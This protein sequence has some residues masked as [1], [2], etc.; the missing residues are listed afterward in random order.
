MVATR[1]PN[2]F[3]TKETH[4]ASQPKKKKKSLEE[5]RKEIMANKTMRSTL[6]NG[7]GRKGSSKGYKAGHN[8][9]TLTQNA[10][11]I[12]QE[13]EDQNYMYSY[14]GNTQDFTRGELEFYQEHYGAYFE[15]MNKHAEE[16]RHK[17]R[18]K[19][20]QDRYESKM[21][22]PT[23]EILQIGKMNNHASPEELKKAVERYIDILSKTY[24]SNLHI[25]NYAIHNDEKVPHCHLR[26]VIDCKDE[27]TG[28]R[29][30]CVEK[31][32][33]ELGIPLPDPTHTQ[34]MKLDKKTG[35]QVEDKKK[36][37]RNVTFTE[38]IRG[39]WNAAIEGETDIS[40]NY[41][42]DISQE[43]GLTMSQYI[44]NQ[45]E[46]EMDK[47][48]ATKEEVARQQQVLLDK[49]GQ[50]KLFS[51]VETVTIPKSEYQMLVENSQKTQ[52]LEQRVQTQDVLDRREEQLNKSLRQNNHILQHIKETVKESVEK[53]I[54][55]LLSPLQSKIA[56]LTQHIRTLTHTQRTLAAQVESERQVTELQRKIQDNTLNFYKT[57]QQGRIEYDK[58]IAYDDLERSIYDELDRRIGIGEEDKQKHSMG[59]HH[60]R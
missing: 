56:S 29:Y 38:Q 5:R 52:E 28:L 36:N 17:E 7:K 6:H 1:H 24:G 4:Q 22:C 34:Y 55:T 26:Y 49:E 47:L 33:E 13:R 25:L 46:K 30:P 10:Q 21:Y 32:L 37:N 48:E 2:T 50:K 20:L 41:I 58:R 43:K 8:D 14:N 39:I 35:K 44:Q 12:D 9:R 31:G 15:A 53:A 45:Q 54:H 42:P 40:I 11:H 59:Y 16:I 3:E 57:F 60:S 51:K 19:P 23:E 18:I 27:K